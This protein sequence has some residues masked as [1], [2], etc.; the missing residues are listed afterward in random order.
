MKML[1]R[2]A[3]GAREL[4]NIAVDAAET[5]AVAMVGQPDDAVLA[6][7]EIT[8]ANLSRDL[9]PEVGAVAAAE[10]ADIFVRA[11]MGE[12]REREAL[13]AMGLL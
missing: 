3:A 12:K 6:H 2:D 7:L 11:V 5:I 9:T 13:A 10:F 1:L 4:I 8:R